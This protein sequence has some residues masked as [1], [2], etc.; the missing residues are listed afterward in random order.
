MDK[1]FWMI[2][3]VVA[4]I[5]GG[6]F[7]VTNTNKAGGPSDVK[8]TLTNH[9]EGNNS[10]GVTLTEYGDFQCPACGQY[11]NPLK[12]VFSKYKDQIHF[13]FRNFPLYT[14]HPNAIAGA[15]AAEAAD[16]QGK[17][18]EMHDKLYDENYAQQLAQAQGSTYATWTTAKDPEN[19]FAD[20]AKSLGLNVE[21]FKSDFKSKLVNDRVQA[22]LAEG[23]KL[24]VQATPTFF[25]NGKKISSPDA[26][27][28]AFSKVLDAAI[29]QQK[30]TKK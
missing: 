6:I 17:Y 10:A 1:R 23:N 30:D 21:K 26:T 18:W 27:L 12:E 25:I 8:G 4:V 24:K 22:D 16:L 13:Q 19:D 5:L 14:I 9:V 7:F 28:E 2:L 3:V 29:A 11:Y 15:R 20:Y